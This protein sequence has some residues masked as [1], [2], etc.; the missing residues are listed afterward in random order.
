MKKK[1]EIL[2]LITVVMFG[3]PWAAVTFA[4][5]DASMAICFVL[6]F[7]INFLCSILAGVFSGLEI[8]RYFWLPAVNAVMFLLG[9]WTVFDWGNPDFYGYAAAYL[10]TGFV[11]MVTVY[12][13]RKIRRLV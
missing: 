9:V 5:G 12:G 10:V 1:I 2:L 6:F 7:G 13:V 11:T 8:K 3:F 4:P